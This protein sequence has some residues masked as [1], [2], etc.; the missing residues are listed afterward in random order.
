MPPLQR[1]LWGD[2]KESSRGVTA[3]AG[4][5]ES[6]ADESDHCI[7]EVLFFASA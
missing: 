3:D 2:G 6:P 5:R 7:T 4:G 1:S